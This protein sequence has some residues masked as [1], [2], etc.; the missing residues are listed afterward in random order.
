MVLVR[1]IIAIIAPYNLFKEPS[2]ARERVFVLDFG[3]WVLGFARFY[4]FRPADF[5]A[6]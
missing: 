2:F 1:Q 6:L 5:A 3:F 4:F